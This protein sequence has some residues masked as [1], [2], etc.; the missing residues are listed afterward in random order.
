MF[1]KK[2][3]NWIDE[4]FSENENKQI[5]AQKKIIDNLSNEI[6]DLK[7]QVNKLVVINK[8]LSENNK[9]LINENSKLKQQLQNNNQKI[10]YYDLICKVVE[11]DVLKQVIEM[12]NRK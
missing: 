10:A 2:L 4:Y 12:S 5:K 9:Q 6:K 7:E 3:W 8:K 11:D 1:L